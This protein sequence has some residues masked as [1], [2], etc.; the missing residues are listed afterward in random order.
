MGPLI[1]TQD[2]RHARTIEGGK[3]APLNHVRVPSRHTWGLT[4]VDFSPRGPR[5]AAHPTDSTR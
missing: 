4:H 3:M 5:P 2:C 1:F